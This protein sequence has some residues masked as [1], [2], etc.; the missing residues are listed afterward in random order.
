MQ[1]W[2]SGQGNPEWRQLLIHP[3]LKHRVC[4]CCSLLQ[5]RLRNRNGLR[6]SKS[7]LA[8]PQNVE[9]SRRLEE[10]GNWNIHVWMLQANLHSSFGWGEEI[11]LFRQLNVLCK[12]YCQGGHLFQGWFGR[13]MEGIRWVSHST[14]AWKYKVSFLLLLLSVW[15]NHGCQG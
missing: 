2:M 15:C 14:H 13:A 9:G 6:L 8:Q 10:K 1:S 11:V 12:T 4:S 7:S 3:A 5:N